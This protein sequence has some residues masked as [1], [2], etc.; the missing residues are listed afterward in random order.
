MFKERFQCLLYLYWIKTTQ[1]KTNQQKKPKPTTKAIMNTLPFFI[2][3]SKCNSCAHEDL[4][5]VNSV[6][7]GTSPPSWQ[8]AWS[9]LFSIQRGYNPPIGKG[10]RAAV[11]HLT[12]PLYARL[13]CFELPWFS[14]VSWF[15]FIVTPSAKDSR[16]TAQF[17][18]MRNRNNYG[19]IWCSSTTSATV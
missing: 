12:S 19:S 18:T 15:K 3:T 5:G 6:W 13:R 10:G 17:I 9:V 11:R 4:S 16:Y 14:P 8:Q 1:N 7:A 2:R